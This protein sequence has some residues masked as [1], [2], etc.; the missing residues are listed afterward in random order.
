MIK[1]LPS[2]IYT[3]ASEKLSKKVEKE[4][5][6]SDPEENEAQLILSEAEITSSS[7]K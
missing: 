6:I 1:W 2:V 4:L 7:D 3:W 5:E